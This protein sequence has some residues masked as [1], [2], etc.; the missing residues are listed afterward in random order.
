ME[1]R[2]E[3]IKVDIRVPVGVPMLELVEFA[4]RCEAAVFTASASTTTSTAAA[5][6]RLLL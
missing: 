1:D 2:S 6:L 5:L 3:R 4:R